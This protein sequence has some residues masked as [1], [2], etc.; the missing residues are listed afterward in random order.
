[1]SS[2]P[3]PWRDRLRPAQQPG[4]TGS[5]PKNHPEEPEPWESPDT[6]TTTLLNES[7]DLDQPWQVLI[8]N[9]PVNL[10]SYVT[11]VIRRIFGYSETKAR[12]HMMQIHREGKTIAWTG[13]RERAEAYVH[14]LQSHQLLAS[15]HK[16]SE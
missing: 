16:A 3:E 11:V 7:E 1:M 12:K 6:G 2:V 13:G 9:D 4:T 5:A 10:M 8:F 14:Q 15:L